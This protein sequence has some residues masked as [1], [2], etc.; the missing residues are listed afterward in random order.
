MRQS[1]CELGMIYGSPVGRRAVLSTP[2]AERFKRH[3]YKLEHTGSSPVRGTSSKRL[4]EVPLITAVRQCRVRTEASASPLASALNWS[5]VVR[6]SWSVAAACKAV[7][8]CPLVGSN[9]TTIT[10]AFASMVFNGEHASLPN[11]R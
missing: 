4:R 3:P 1:E 2:V 6:R 7:G 5:L 9:P 10:K 11:L 8:L